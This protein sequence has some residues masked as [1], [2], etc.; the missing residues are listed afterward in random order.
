MT[1]HNQRPGPLE[2][3]DENK[4]HSTLTNTLITKTYT[5]YTNSDPLREFQL[6]LRDPRQTKKRG[7]FTLLDLVNR[8]ISL[9]DILQWI[10]N[11]VLPSRLSSAT[12]NVW[13]SPKI[14]SSKSIGQ[15]MKDILTQATKAVCILPLY[16]LS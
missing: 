7:P 16:G 5:V 12:I 11:S 2:E 3:L 4:Y 8:A 1:F 9:R 13:I 6:P 15:K 14:S 10:G